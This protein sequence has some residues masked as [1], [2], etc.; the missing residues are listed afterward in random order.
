MLSVFMTT[1]SARGDNERVVGGL[2]HLPEIGGRAAPHAG[3]GVGGTAFVD[4]EPAI[5]PVDLAAILFR[6]THQ[7]G[8]RVF[9]DEMVLLLDTAAVHCVGMRRL[10]REGLQDRTL[11]GE[12]VDVV[13]ALGREID[14][15][16]RR[17]RAG[18]LVRRIHDG[19]RDGLLVGHGVL[20]QCQITL[21]PSARASSTTS[22]GAAATPEAS[23]LSSMPRSFS[24]KLSAR[25]RTP[26]PARLV[27][28]AERA[29][30]RT[31]STP[32]CTRNRVTSFF[33][34]ASC[35]ARSPQKR[36]SFES[37]GSRDSINKYLG[38]NTYPTN[39]KPCP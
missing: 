32:F 39:V 17:R 26:A 35:R 1:S 22:S 29:P 7:R 8:D 16:H 15:P 2:G 31:G 27:R 9:R 23:R 21:A 30:A 10:R 37:N 13:A 11:I 19:D 18:V 3:Y 24:E 14:Q 4:A 12:D 5:H 34:A 28:S 20:P 25:T 33:A 36:V 38:I 6:L